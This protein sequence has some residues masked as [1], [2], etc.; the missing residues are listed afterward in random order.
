MNAANRAVL[1]VSADFHDAAAAV[2]VDG[3]LTAAAAEERFSRVKHDPSFP[4]EAIRWC[5]EACEVAP[6][7]LE[8]VAFYEKPFTKLERIL[9]THAR[10][11]PRSLP[12]LRRSVSSFAARSVWVGPRISQVLDELGHSDVD[13]VYA[14]HHLSHA[15]AAFFPSP[16]DRSA[17]LTV[18]GVGELTTAS[19]GIGDANTIELVEEMSYPSSVGLFYAA[20]TEFCGFAVNDGE[21]KLMG[22]APYGTPRYVDVLRER[23][24]S[25]E[26]DGSIRL[27]GRWFAFEKGRWMTSGALARLLDGPRRSAG[28]PLTQREA[29]IAA[30]AQVLLEDVL[31]RMAAHARSLTGAR[32]LSMAGGVALNCV[33]NSAI[34]D[35]GLFDEVWVQPAPGDDGGAVGAALWAWHQVLGNPRP[36]GRAKDGMSGAVLGPAFSDEAIGEWL[37]GNSIPFRVPPDR[38]S[39]N[40]EVAAALARGETVGWFQGGMEFGPRALGHR[41]ILADPRDPGMID[42]LNR[43]VKRRESFRPFA[44]AVLAED[45]GRWFDTDLAHPYMLHTVTVRDEHRFEGSVGAEDLDRQATPGG[46]DGLVGRLHAERSAISACTHVDHSAR[47]QTVDADDHPELHGLLRAFRDLTGCPVL[48]NT[49]FNRRDEP[50]VCTPADAVQCFA[51]TDLDLLVLGLN[52]VSQTDLTAADTATGVGS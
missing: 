41:S 48:I 20:L 8:M 1:G 33:A 29:D 13:L 22:L 37:A 39:L 6:G 9:S 36:T 32:H 24:I 46:Q 10:V 27:D 50:I 3:E 19:I 42:R 7:D 40:R 38:D 14:E 23:V 45:V 26:D 11:G 17:I 49:S 4:A 35:G 16:F 44:P 47:V 21:S 2:V 31:V 34:R 18:D 43:S 51:D 52:V 28:D 12:R 5:L 30:S 15:A 25:I